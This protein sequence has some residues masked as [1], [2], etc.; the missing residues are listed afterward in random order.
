MSQAVNDELVLQILKVHSM[1][2]GNLGSLDAVPA[3]PSKGSSAPSEENHRKTSSQQQNI[4]SHVT[5]LSY[6]LPKL[7]PPAYRPAKSVSPH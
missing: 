4:V 1:L 2:L 6:S 5:P 3:T 7:L